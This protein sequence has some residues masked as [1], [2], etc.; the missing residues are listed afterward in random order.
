LRRQVTS[1]QGTTERAI[2][3][4]ERAGLKALFDRATDAAVARSRELATGA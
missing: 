1:P 3:E 4:L 2:A